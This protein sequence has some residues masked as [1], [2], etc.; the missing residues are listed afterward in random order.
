MNTKKLQSFN[1]DGE[2]L[3]VIFVKTQKVKD[4][5]IC[6]VYAFAG[7]TTKDLG[8]VTVR[9][10][11]STPMQ[12]VL[13]GKSTIEGFISGTGTLFVKQADGKEV[14]YIFDEASKAG[15]P[16]IEILLNEIMQWK[17]SGGSDLVFYEVCEP[18]YT[19]GRFGEVAAA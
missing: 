13:Q 2:V 6:D 3:E 9:Q 5:V 10:G 8:V 12:K 19:E 7:D 16:Q 14:N 1:L 17:A 4:G 18:S 11:C 15:K